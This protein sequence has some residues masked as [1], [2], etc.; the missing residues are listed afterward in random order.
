VNGFAPPGSRRGAFSVGDAGAAVGDVVVAVVVVVVVSGAGS[1]S[2]AHDA[3]KPTIAMTASPPATAE[4][5]RVKQCD[6]M[7]I[8]FFRSATSQFSTQTNMA[9]GVHCGVDHC[10]VNFACQQVCQN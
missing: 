8:P 3:V 5:F 9:E 4:S 10:T 6:C 7:L 1:S 2:V